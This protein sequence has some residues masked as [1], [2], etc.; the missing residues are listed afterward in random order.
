[1]TH[2]E[3][4]RRGDEH[5]IA[6]LYDHY[7]GVVYSISLSVLR[8]PAL[9]EQI[10]SDI[11]FE[12]WRSPECF[13]QQTGSLFLFLAI[14]ARNR[15]FE[16]LRHKPGSVVDFASSCGISNDR[17]HNM[18]RAAACAAFN[19]LPTDRRQTLE[20]AFFNGMTQSEISLTSS[21]RET[22][23][24]L[25]KSCAVSQLADTGLEVVDLDSDPAFAR[26]QLHVRDV[27]SHIEGM[28]RLARVLVGSPKNLLQELVTAAVDFCGADSAGIGIEQEDGTDDNFYHWVATAGHYSRFF[29][30]KAATLSQCLWFDPGT[31]T[32]ADLSCY[33][34]VLRPDGYRGYYGD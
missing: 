22:D 9:A 13:A 16:M 1:M 6:L 33:A 28:N 20:R 2:L 11:F 12:V 21:P 34:A 4:V 5:A 17:E 15:A 19:E 24:Q 3:R 30:C 18:S 31:G 27:A 23:E 7:S 25:V 8:D 10:L 26:R 14:I 32:P 29:G